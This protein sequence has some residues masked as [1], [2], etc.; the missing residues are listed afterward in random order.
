[1]QT[2]KRTPQNPPGVPLTSADFITPF[3]PSPAPRWIRMPPS[4]KPNITIHSDIRPSGNQFLTP[5][6]P[7]LHKPLNIRSNYEKESPS[8]LDGDIKTPHSVPTADFSSSL[9]FTTTM[10]EV[11]IGKPCNADLSKSHPETQMVVDNED[12]SDTTIVSPVSGYND[13]ESRI[14]HNEHHP[15]NEYKM[16]FS[17]DLFDT[18]LCTQSSQNNTDMSPASSRGNISCSPPLD[19]SQSSFESEWQKAVLSQRKPVQN[20]ERAREFNITCIEKKLPDSMDI[21]EAEHIKT[22]YSENDQQGSFS[23]DYLMYQNSSED[24]ATSLGIAQPLKSKEVDENRV[25]GYCGDTSE[26]INQYTNKQ[27]TSFNN[28]LENIEVQTPEQPIKVAQP[29]SSITKRLQ[30]LQRGKQVKIPK[31][32]NEIS[33]SPEQKITVN[34][35][36]S[37]LNMIGRI[38]SFNVIGG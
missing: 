12:M 36:E 37:D 5:D 3:T 33:K 9:A 18:S 20:T 28:L 19:L 14:P 38:L 6:L 23:I 27:P 34:L 32:D 11:P 22:K 7:I 35:D 13:H 31:T 4:Q 30:E 29:V 16:E 17:Q 10:P 25:N 1:M 26:Y 24:V 15:G 8:G 2:Q 21:T